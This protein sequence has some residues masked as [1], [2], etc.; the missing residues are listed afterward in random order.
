M[1]VAIG[2]EADVVTA[3]REARRLASDLG[4]PATACAH[5]ATAV[6][7]VAGNVRLYAGRGEVLL[8]PAEE[9]GAVGITVV[10]TDAGPGIP[11]VE[12]AMQDGW[13]TAGSMGLGLPGA[14]RL[15][16]EFEISSRAGEGTSVT[17]RKWRP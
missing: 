14:R 3:C 2:S 13:S 9:L 6:S 1:R 8:A 15:M 17:V 4:F 12:L 11:D 5:V 10:A 16:D 7:E